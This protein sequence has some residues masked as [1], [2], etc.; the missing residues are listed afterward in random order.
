MTMSGTI[1]FVDRDRRQL[2]D[3]RRCRLAWAAA[4]GEWRFSL[5][6]VESVPQPDGEAYA[7]RFESEDGEQVITLP[8]PGAPVAMS[9]GAEYH[10]RSPQ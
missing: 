8:L 6:D 7:L 2:G 5:L 1:C 4:S 3:G 9:A 10:L